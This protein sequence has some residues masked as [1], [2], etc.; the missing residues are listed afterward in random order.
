MAGRNAADALDSAGPEALMTSS[1][2][3]L[4]INPTITSQRHAR[5]PLAVMSLSAAL[6]GRHSSTIIDGNVDRDFIAT[7]ARMVDEGRVDCVG[8]TVMGGPQLS[9]AIA[10]SKAIRELRPGVPI[11]WG[12]AFPTVCPEATVNV[13]YVDYAVRAQGEETLV[14]LLD[15]LAEGRH[16][17]VNSITGLTWRL[18][19]RTVHNKDRKFSAASL[20]RMLPYD[21]LENPRQYLTN[22]YLG[23]RT[24][25]YQASLGG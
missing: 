23:R 7:A 16:E 20:G 21:K 18:G 2:R 9:T 19:D 12:G 24:I 15:A 1:R 10:V 5:F 6:E 22:T 25:G 17:A 8:V 13:P 14:E 4:L 3:I 11:I